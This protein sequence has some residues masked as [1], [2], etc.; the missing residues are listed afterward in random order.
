MVTFYYALLLLHII[1]IR[2]FIPIVSPIALTL[3]IIIFSHACIN[4]CHM[5]NAKSPSG[6]ELKQY[7]ILQDTETRKF[8]F[9]VCLSLY[10][11]SSEYLWCQNNLKRDKDVR[12]KEHSLH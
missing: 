3:Q 11:L 5:H 7:Q 6:C 9:P 4:Y 10:F 12:V 8:F 1:F 2:V